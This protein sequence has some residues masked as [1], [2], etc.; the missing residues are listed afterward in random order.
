VSRMNSVTPVA[1][2]TTPAAAVVAPAAK[3]ISYQ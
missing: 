3:A 1:T 2:L